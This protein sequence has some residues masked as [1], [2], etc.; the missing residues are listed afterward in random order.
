MRRRILDPLALLLALAPLAAC[1]RPPDPDRV[2]ERLPELPAYVA[3]N[4]EP[5]KGTDVLATKAPPPMHKPTQ[6]LV[7]KQRACTKSYFGYVVYPLTVCTRP[8]DAIDV[9][10]LSAIEAQA[11]PSRWSP[12]VQ[13]TRYYKL[14]KSKTT[15]ARLFCRQSGGPWYAE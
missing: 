3:A 15:Q 10:Q 8:T 11:P 6:P 4:L 13:T 1:S 14:S 5:I 9:D 12:S 2:V 7:Q